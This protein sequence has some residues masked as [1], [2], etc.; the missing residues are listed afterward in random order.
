MT[1][2]ID[3]EI[4]LRRPPAPVG[5][6]DARRYVTREYLELEMEHLWPRTWLLACI[7]SEI[8][9]VGDFC[10][11]EIG[12]VSIIV[13]RAT[14]GSLRAYQNS[15]QHRGRKIKEGFGNSQQLRCPFHGWTWNLDGELGEVPMRETYAPFDDETCRL[16]QVRVEQWNDWI[17]VN[18]D[19]EAPSLADYLGELST[20]MAPFAHTEQ[21]RWKNETILVRAN[22]KSV[23]DAFLEGYHGQSLHVEANAFIPT[24][25]IEVQLIGDHLT[26]TAPIGVPDPYRMPYGADYEEIVDAMEWA[27]GSLSSDASL[28]VA[29][30]RQMSLEPGQTFRE[31]LRDVIKSASAALDIDISG[32]TEDQL[33]LATNFFVFPNTSVHCNILGYFILRML[34]N[35]DDPDSSFL[36]MW[37]FKRPDGPD[38]PPAEPN[39]V[40][41]EGVTTR[42]A[43]LDQDLANLRL[44][45]AGLR[46]PNFPGFRFSDLESGIAH[47]NTV[48]DRYIGVQ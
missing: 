1:A 29:A 37:W 11:Y 24:T 2:S 8:P 47:F 21:Y 31:L 30:F 7:A 34:P 45:Q 9:N 32:L 6:F 36:H 5:L 26:N 44:Y 18:L 22:W 12:R 43:V 38:M 28:M 23:I 13:V 3:Q 33:T 14:D 48:L 4:R 10:E 25:D 19:P 46:N 15:C 35:G 27:M 40:I 17:F 42:S 41:P 16:P 39:K 20:L